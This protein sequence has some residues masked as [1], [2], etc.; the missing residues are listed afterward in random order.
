MLV[1]LMALAFSSHALHAEEPDRGRPN[2]LFC[3]ADDQSYPHASAYGEPVIETPV[4]DRVAREGV[5]FTQAYCASPSCT[6]SRSAILTGQDIW[7]LGEGGQL[8]GTLPAEHPVYTDLLTG[9]GYHVGYMDKGWAPGNDRAGGR[10]SNPAG[11]KF[12]SFR[13][14]LAEAPEGK[15]WCFWF[16]SRDPHRGYRKG[17]GVRAG[18]DPA[19]VRVPLVYPDTPEVRSDLCDYFFEIQR[20]DQQIGGMLE[21]IDQA[22]Q[23]DDTLVVITSDNG[24]P[25]PRAK[26][27]LYDLGTHVPLAIRWPNRV[28]GGRTI[29]DFVNLTDLAPTFLEA[30]GL[31]PSKSMSGRSL[32]SLLTSSKSGNVE[33]ERDAVYAGRER[34]AW[35]RLEGTGYPMRMIR[36]RD[37]LFVRNYEPDRWPAGIYRMVTNEGHYGDVDASPTKDVMIGLKDP[38]ARLFAL[39]FGKRPGEELYDC[40]KD[41]HQLLNLTSDPAY[42][43]TRRELSE[44]LAAH[45][46]ATGDPRQTTGETP[47]D[48]WPYHGHNQWEVLPEQASPAELDTGKEAAESVRFDPVIKDIEG[49]TVHV[50][51]KLLEG[52]FAGEGARALKM[53]ANHLQRIAILMPEQRLV[54]MRELEIWIEHDHPEID[55]EPGPY[56]PSVGWLTERGY[57]ARLAKK[58]HVTRAASLLERHHMIKH[59]A[60]ILHELVHAYHHQ[61][62][63]FDEPRIKAV[64]EQAMEAGLYDQVLLYTG[65]TVRAYAATNEMEYFAEGTEAYFYRN[66]F[67]PF[68]RAE[69]EQH[70]PVLHDLLE[71]IWGRLE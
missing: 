62:L 16:G 28:V 13:E 37:F 33:P 49:W 38:H 36:T 51:P 15:P 48:A 60:V 58:V 47:W 8:F 10:G 24:M 11:T 68:V 21:L 1:G 44:R 71:E 2:I 32:L 26:A 17:S 7:R 20:F 52:E 9:S 18:M 67:Y 64:Y 3:L 61:V 70:D 53:L 65:E 5:L 12:G 50:D 35:C 23:L 31:T 42:E 40:E 22:G 34:H 4:F 41:P 25:F 39:S 54:E 66:D 19:E 27:N 55:V 6:P 45:L 14:F 29:D 59:P 56:H 57:D 63:G 46:K 30:A 69:L 43:R